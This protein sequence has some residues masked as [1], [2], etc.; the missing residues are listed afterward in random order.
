MSFISAVLAAST[1]KSFMR[2][3]SASNA[4]NLAF[5]IDIKSDGKRD[6]NV[7]ENTNIGVLAVFWTKIDKI[8]KIGT[9]WNNTDLSPNIA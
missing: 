2:S 4:S 5:F 8:V 6:D 7:R 1:L 3:S 9:S